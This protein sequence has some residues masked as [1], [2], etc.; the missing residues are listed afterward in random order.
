MDNLGRVRIPVKKPV[1]PLFLCINLDFINFLCE[2]GCI[3]CCFPCTF[4]E[5][6]R[7]G[8]CVSPEPVGTVN[9]SCDFAAGI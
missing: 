1:E 3:S 2:A 9:A 8:Q 6:L 5:Y 4:S 7:I